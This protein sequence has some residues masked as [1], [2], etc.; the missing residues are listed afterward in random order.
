MEKL[1]SNPISIK[2]FVQN[3][4]VNRGSRS[5][6]ITCGTPQYFTTCLKKSLVASSAVQSAGTGMKV[7]YL[8][9]MSTI[10]MMLPH[11]SD[12]GRQV[13]KSMEILSYGFFGAG[14]GS[15]RPAGHCCSILSY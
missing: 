12:L 8:E 5:L 1:R 10:T 2:S 4:H 13:I 11:P 3:L 14:R 6:M 9:N 15:R 7:A